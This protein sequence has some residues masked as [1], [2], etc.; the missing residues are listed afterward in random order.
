V[1]AFERWIS[2]GLLPSSVVHLFCGQ[3]SLMMMNQNIIINL[4]KTILFVID[5]AL[6]Q[7][8]TD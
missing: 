2:G 8:L 5:E 6:K 1:S 4:V 3:P 7:I